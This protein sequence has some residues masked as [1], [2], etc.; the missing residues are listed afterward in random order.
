M[1][2]NSR[3]RFYEQRRSRSSHHHLLLLLHHPQQHLQHEKIVNKVGEETLDFAFFPYHLAMELPHVGKQCSIATCNALGRM[4]QE[5][6]QRHCVN[7]REVL[8][9]QR[10]SALQLSLLSWNLLASLKVW[11]GCQCVILS[12]LTAF[13][14]QWISWTSQRP[15]LFRDGARKQ[16]SG[17]VRQVRKHDQGAWHWKLDAW[18]NCMY[19]KEYIRSMSDR[20][21]KGY[22]SHRSRMQKVRVRFI[23]FNVQHKTARQSMRVWRMSR[24]ATEKDINTCTLHWMSEELLFKVRAEWIVSSLLSSDI[25]K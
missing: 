22:A 25:R 24:I 23:F 21:H 14:F 17:S 12:F 5:W 19:W 11:R 1:H 10:L 4:R 20:Y 15:W 3:H 8:L 16:A 9:E 13:L 2:W 6:G 7:R 18:R